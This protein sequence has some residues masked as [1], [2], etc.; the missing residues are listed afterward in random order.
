MILQK[1][2]RLALFCT[3]LAM[4]PGV[5]AAKADRDKPVYV[6]ADEAN[7]DDAR[8]VSIFTGNV[9]LSQGTLLISGDQ[10]VALQD[11]SGFKY[12]TVTGN[13][14]SFRQQRKGADGYVEGYGERIEYN[15]ASEIM[16]IYGQAHVKRGQ[17][18]VHGEHITYNART[19]VFQVSS[20]HKQPAHEKEHRVR[21]IIQP[22]G[23]AASTPSST[24]PLS[25]KPDTTLIKPKDNK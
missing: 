16:N 9:R 18:D 10:I 2:K 15:A 17:D 24:E 1:T 7:I 3:L 25:I 22:Q 14:A 5:Y 23:A 6:E 4:V 8:Q 20:A 21:V 19:G 11:R 13:L 12:G